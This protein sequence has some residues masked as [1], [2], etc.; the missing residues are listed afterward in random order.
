MTTDFQR[1][2]YRSDIQGLRAIAIALVVLAHAQ[3][4]GLS[5]GFAG[6]DVFFVLSGYLITGLLLSELSANGRIRYGRFLARRLKRLLPG[7]LVMVMG[8][9][10][11]ASLLL[12]DYE[13]RIQTESFA[14]AATWTSNLYFALNRFDYFE[15]LSKNDLFLH[16]WSLGVEEQFYVVWPWVLAVCTA[17]L[18]AGQGI[19]CRRKVLIYGLVTVLLVCLGLCVH[20]GEYNALFGFYMMPSRGWQFALGA[21]AFV[22]LGVSGRDERDSVPPGVF[23]MAGGVGLLLIILSSSMLHSGVTYPSFRAIAPSAGAALIII[24]GASPT[25]LTSLLS[26]RALT[27]LGDR[28]YSLYLWHWP[29]LQIGNSYGLDDSLGGTGFLLAVSLLLADLSYRHIELPFWKGRFSKASELK[30]LAASLGVMVVTVALGAGTTAMSSGSGD[31]ARANGDTVPRLDRPH[32]YDND[33][34]CDSWYRSAE[35]IPCR[36]ND[37][38]GSAT[39]MLLGDSVGVQWAPAFELLYRP[40]DW[41]LIVLTKSGCAMVDETYYYEPVGGEYEICAQWR[42]AALDYVREISPELVIVGS[43]SHYDFS[44]HQWIAGSRRILT[45]LSQAAGS[46]MII[47]GTPA[48]SFHGPACIESPGRFSRR[49]AD[50]RREC[51]EALTDRRSKDVVAYLF[52]AAAGLEGVS[53]LSLNDLVCPADRC[54]AQALDG[55]VVYRD[56]RHLTASFVRT[57]ASKIAARIADIEVESERAAAGTSIAASEGYGR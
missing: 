14:F 52:N 31:V 41:E 27:W 53:V 37:D 29:T 44:P 45:E 2:D 38:R 26:S 21:L 39:V 51:E 33:R 12:S 9:M 7:M 30:T 32:F 10:V 6:V 50:S 3:V 56:A 42:R 19:L 4:P 23:L 35:L 20:W 17:G 18:A 54:A 34:D 36:V 43:S 22:L 55:R 11:L 57:K 8:V 25:I 28:S 15:E 49:L 1:L 48:L 13:A 5:G 40:P 16:T 46:V 24:A 47:P